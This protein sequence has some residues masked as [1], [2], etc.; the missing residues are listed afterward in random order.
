MIKVSK[1]CLAEE[2]LAEIK[3]TFDY[4]YFGLA[5]KVIEFEDKL[6]EYLGAKYVVATNTG[7]SALHLALDALGIGVGDEVIVP[8][9]TFVGCFQAI[10]ATGAT[11]IP[12][13]ICP[14][15]LLTDIDDASRRITAKTKAIMPVHYAG[16]PCNMDA[17][18]KMKKE[19]G[20]RVIE[21]AAHALGSYYRSKK[22]GSFG[23]I[24]CF[25]FD[26]I[27]N[28][29]CGEG[30]AIVCREDD[31][32]ERLRQKRLLGIDRKSHTCSWKERSWFYE[33]KTQGF[34]YHMS[35]KGD[36]PKV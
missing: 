7:T 29:T 36:L 34:R 23:D 6:R 15:T 17:L 26:S 21:D 2:E 16:N 31:L 27:K 10:S 11:P 9:L 22:I 3:G 32:A 14:D 25:S 1:G 19:Y 12:C 24:A 13:D 4:G 18:M 5:Y 8:S 20:I 35:Q 28:I 33:V 30:G